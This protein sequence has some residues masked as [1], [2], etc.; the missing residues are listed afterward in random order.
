MSS[1]VAE[2]LP[3]RSAVLSRHRHRAAAEQF[4][5]AHER[6]A[7]GRVMQVHV[8]RAHRIDARAAADHA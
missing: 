4:M 2:E 6:L 7:A 1:G 8:A 5:R 3:A